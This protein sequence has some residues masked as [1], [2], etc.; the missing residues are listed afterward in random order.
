MGDPPVGDEHAARQNLHTVGGADLI[1]LLQQDVHQVVRRRLLEIGLHT[2]L[3][4]GHH[5]EMVDVLVLPP[6]E[7]GQQRVAGGAGGAGED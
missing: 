3:A 5:H 1:V 4:D 2:A 6:A 7:V